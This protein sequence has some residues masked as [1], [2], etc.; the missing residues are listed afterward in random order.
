MSDRINLDDL[1]YNGDEVI[2]KDDRAKKLYGVLVVIAIAV[3]VI[4]LYLSNKGHKYYI[5]KLPQYSAG[6]VKVDGY[7]HK[8]K[9]CC[10]AVADKFGAEVI[11]VSPRDI[12]GTN[13]YGQS[14]TYDKAFLHCPLCN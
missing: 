12:A 7:M 5:A 1:S 10:Q 14:I 6:S 4:G 9:S 13:S 11:E 8:S 3:I 2:I